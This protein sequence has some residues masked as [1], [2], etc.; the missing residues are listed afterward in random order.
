VANREQSIL[1]ALTADNPSQQR[2]LLLV[3]DA[4]GERHSRRAK[5]AI[6]LG[7]ILS[8]TTALASA[9]IVSRLQSYWTKLPVDTLKIDRSFVLAMMT[10]ADGMTLVSVIINLAHAL[11]LKVVAEGVETE[12]QFRQLGLLQCDEIQGFLIGRPVPVETFEE[13]YLSVIVPREQHG[14]IHGNVAPDA[15]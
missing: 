7:S 13:K 11:K 15:A 1:L 3:R 14:H 9:W 6:V 10:S 4:D 8:L 5:M 12:Q 2:R